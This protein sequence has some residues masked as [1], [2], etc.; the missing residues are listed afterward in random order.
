M[1]NLTAVEFFDDF[2]QLEHEVLAVSAQECF[3]KMLELL[4]WDIS[5]GDKRL[6]FAFVFVSLGVQ[7]N[8]VELPAGVVVLANKP[9]RVKAIVEL[10][11]E[12][13]YGDWMNF[14]LAASVKGS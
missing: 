9:G 11:E 10:V 14:R 6:G 13:V 5:M 3:E 7:V 12:V 8:L 1:F 4:G 2:S